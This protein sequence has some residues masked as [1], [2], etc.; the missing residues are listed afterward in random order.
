MKTVRHSREAR[1][2]EVV[3]CHMSISKLAKRR[4]QRGAIAFRSPSPLCARA[5]EHVC[6]CPLPKGDL[7]EQPVIPANAGTQRK[8]NATDFARLLRWRFLQFG[9]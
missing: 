4:R 2:C 3:T 6:K 8:D 1:C 7:C 9:I 5:C